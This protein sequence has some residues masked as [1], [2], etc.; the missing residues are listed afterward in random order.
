LGSKWGNDVP[1]VETQP[2]G[3]EAW[4]VGGNPFPLLGGA[5]AGAG[6][7]DRSET[8]RRW[9]DVP[10][11]YYEPRARLEAMDRDGVDCSVLYPMASGVAGEVLGRVEDPELRVACVQA[12][13][14]WL[15]DE[16]TAKDD[17]FIAHCLL[18]LTSVEAAVAEARRAVGRGHRGVILPA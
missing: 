16:W 6:L 8:P 10:R 9:A 11:S 12:Y 4:V 7:G 3:S 2:D 5:T 1:R 14:D 18:P 17:R 13:N 15:I